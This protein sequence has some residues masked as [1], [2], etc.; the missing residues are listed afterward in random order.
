MSPWVL[1]PAAV[2]V[3]ALAVVAALQL[4]RAERA[5][6]ERDQKADEVIDLRDTVAGLLNENLYL[7][8]QLR[9]EPTETEL[10]V[11]QALRSGR[12][13]WMSS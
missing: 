9:G 11:V 2:M 6:I 1:L 10:E 8:R 4:R 3:V 7:R 5:E 13:W 12:P